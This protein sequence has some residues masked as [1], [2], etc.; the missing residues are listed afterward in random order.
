MVGVESDVGYGGCEDVNKE[1]KI[2][3]NVHKGIVQ[4]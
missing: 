1:Y 3:Y 4:Y 2:L